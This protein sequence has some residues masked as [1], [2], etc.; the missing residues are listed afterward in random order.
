[1]TFSAP[2][3]SFGA[4]GVHAFGDDLEEVFKTL[5]KH[6]VKELDTA[7]IYPD[8]EETLGK[9]E[10]PKRFVIS[11][12]APGFAPGSL[13]KQSVLE[14]MEKSL[15]QL[16]VESV[17]IYYLHAP[18]PTVPIE[19][20][21]EAITELYNAG[22]FKRFGVSNFKAEDVQKIY[23][24]QSAKKAVLPT[25]FQ[26]NY[27][28]V[29]RHIET[30]LFPVLRKLGIT[31]YAY[32]PI[33]GGFLVKDADQ[34]RAKSASGR[35]G[36]EASTGEMYKVMYAKETLLDALDEW[37]HIAK[38]AGVSKAALAYRW[39]AYHSALK[40]EHG[41]V[42]IVGASKLTQLEESLTAIEAGPLDAESAKKIDAIWI[43]IEKDAP[44][45]N[46][47]SFAALS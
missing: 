38:A 18:D 41:D 3:I 19:E 25:V 5:E 23:D 45:D 7:N 33:A 32:S 1:M 12:K 43:K 31:F 17:D 16:G 8:S 29:S 9:V 10:A 4:F 22:K 20:T 37:G 47:N 40:A 14:G 36:S 21:L 39:I 28:A 26:G 30:S 15:K 35:F 44:L 13:T 42:I 27:N 2:S 46:Y 24:I 11:T 34:V 6:N